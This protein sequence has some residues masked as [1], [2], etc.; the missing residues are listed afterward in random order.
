MD[1]IR[2]AHETSNDQGHDVAADN[3]RQSKDLRLLSDLEMVCVGGG[4]GGVTWP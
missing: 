3:G 4:D 2:T 1:Q